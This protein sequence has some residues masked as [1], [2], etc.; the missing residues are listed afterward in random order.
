MILES[1]E[2]LLV[3][4]SR[5]KKTLVTCTH[6]FKFFANAAKFWFKLSEPILCF[7]HVIV[8][9][10]AFLPFSFILPN[11]LALGIHQISVALIV[12]IAILLQALTLRLAS[13]YFSSC[14]IEFAT[15]IIKFHANLMVLFVHRP[16]TI[17]ELIQLVCFLVWFWSKAKVIVFITLELC[18]KLVQLLMLMLFLCIIVSQMFAA[19]FNSIIKKSI[20]FSPSTDIGSLLLNFHFTCV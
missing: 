5:F 9:L 3:A 10:L 16:N 19:F 17:V 18:L 20:F 15:G 6:C 11:E 14:D 1:M 2:L 4:M 8:K 13:W 7:N 12:W